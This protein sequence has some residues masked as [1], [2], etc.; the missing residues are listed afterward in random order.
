MNIATVG[1]I[2]PPHFKSTLW[3]TRPGFRVSY[4]G[5]PAELVIERD[6]KIIKT[7]R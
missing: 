5:Y 4:R 3:I 2:G 1:S 6:G 7:V